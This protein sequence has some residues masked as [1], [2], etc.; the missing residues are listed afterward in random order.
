[1]SLLLAYITFVTCFAIMA[2]FLVITTY[3]STVMICNFYLQMLNII[4]LLLVNDENH[5]RLGAPYKSNKYC[6]L[7]K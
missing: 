5:I 7:F 3:Q 4:K 2:R 6:T 1:M